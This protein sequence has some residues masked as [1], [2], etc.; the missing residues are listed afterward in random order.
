MELKRRIRFCT[1][2]RRALSLTIVPRQ[3][4]VHFPPKPPRMVD[5]PIFRGSCEADSGLFVPP[6]EAIIELANCRVDED[7]VRRFTRKYG[8]LVAGSDGKF[9]FQLSDWCAWQSQFRCAWDGFLGLDS[10]Y[11]SA[12]VPL[13]KERAPHLFSEPLKNV[14]SEG[15]F[16]LTKDGVAFVAESLYGGLLLV[17]IA[18][19]ERKLLRHCPKPGCE[20]PYFIA[21]H[22]RQRYCTE[23]CAEWAQ[24]QAK[25]A[26]W[27]DSGKQWLEQ[28]GK[29]ADSKAKVKPKAGRKTN[30][31]KKTR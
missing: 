11:P 9:A 3:I 25:S 19:H 5:D 13:L 14:Q 23:V 24:A 31:A 28:R 21:A 4:P 6:A 10:R 8:P 2:D 18:T 22:P 29:A 30:G 17:L 27:K 20:N 15:R 26:W 12:Y 1:P 7:G 16:E